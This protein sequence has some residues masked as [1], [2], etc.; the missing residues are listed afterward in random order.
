MKRN[1]LVRTLVLLTLTLPGCTSE[2]VKRGTYDALYQKQCMDRSG[3]PNCD[4]EHKSYEQY[5][6][7]RE[8]TLK[9]DR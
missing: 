9:R 2:A 4:A 8:E 3:V 5:K 7:D 1:V 6:K